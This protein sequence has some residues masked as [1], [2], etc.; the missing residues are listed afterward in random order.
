MPRRPALRGMLVVFGI[1]GILIFLNIG[2]CFFS[3]NRFTLPGHG[4]SSGVPDRPIRE[5]A[6]PIYRRN[7]AVVCML[8]F[9]R[10]KWIQ[11]MRIHHEQF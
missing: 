10:L 4:S 2:E 9:F 7:R 8:A 3:K 6:S 11:P 5:F 1:A